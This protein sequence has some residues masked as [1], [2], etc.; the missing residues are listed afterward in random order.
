MTSNMT[1]NII[2]GLKYFTLAGVS[3]LCVSQEAKANLIYGIADDNVIY[4]VSTNTKAATPVF[5]TG[6]SGVS[7][8]F[9]YDAARNDF[10]FVAPNRTLQFWNGGQSLTQ[11]ASRSQLGLASDPNIVNGYQPESAAYYNNAFWFVNEN[12]NRLTQIKLDYSNPNVPTFASKLVYDIANLP[13]SGYGDIAINANTGMLYGATETGL[14][15][16]LNLNG[17]ANSIKNS[18]THIRTGNPSLQLAFSADYSILYGQKYDGGIWSTVNVTTG[19]VTHINGFTTPIVNGHAFR[20]L[21]G[22]AVSPV[23]G[24]PLPVPG[25][26]PFI[27]ATAALAWSR[28][29][30]SRLSLSSES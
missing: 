9:A 6:L 29:L 10:F 17:D 13:A 16:S 30:R 27:G 14:F 20:D 2:R 12:R 26:L 15:Y 24:P 19:A 5:N 8:A 3:F 28:K 23:P 25:P 11:V 22:S 4:Q 18:F 7:N 21:G 1:S